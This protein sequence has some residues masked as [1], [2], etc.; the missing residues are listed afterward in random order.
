MPNWSRYIFFTFKIAKCCKYTIC[1]FLHNFRW[2]ADSQVEKLFAN[3]HFLRH[4][5]TINE[6][7]SVRHKFVWSVFCLIVVQPENANF[8]RKFEISKKILKL[9]TFISLQVRYQ[10]SLS[11]QNQLLPTFLLTE[12]FS[13]I[14][15]MHNCA[16]KNKKTCYIFGLTSKFWEF[17]NKNT[18]VFF[19]FL[20]V[21][22]RKRLLGTHIGHMSP[23]FMYFWKWKTF[24]ADKFLLEINDF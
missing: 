15:F 9:F 11:N 4:S 24:N 2:I 10:K 23:Y 20:S 16:C 8:F 6:R 17:F 13:Q 14:W 22:T 19:D 18:E 7:Q 12:N 5:C 1:L 3:S 21:A